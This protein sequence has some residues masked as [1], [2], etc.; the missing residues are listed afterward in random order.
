MSS[1]GLPSYPVNIAGVE[2]TAPFL[3]N[4]LVKDFF[5]Y[6]RNSFDCMSQAANVGCLVFKSKSID[7]V[8]FPKMNTV[9]S[10]QSYSCDFPQMF[11]WYS[12][13]QNSTEYKYIDAFCNRTK[14]TCDVYLKLSMS[15]LGDNHSADINP[16]FKKGVQHDKQAI[17]DCLDAAFGFLSQRYSD[18]LDALL[19][20]ISQE[21]YIE[22]RYHKLSIY[23]QK[24]KDSPE[25]SFSMAYIDTDNDIS[26]MPDSIQVL[27][28]QERDGDITARN[29]PIDTIYVKVSEDENK[30]IGKYIATEPC[31]DDT[32]LQYR[33]YEKAPY[34]E[35]TLPL[36]FQAMMDEKQKDTFYHADPFMDIRTVS[37]DDDFLKRVQLPF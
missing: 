26:S 23:Q 14:H 4:K 12:S 19:A 1:S 30:Y 9:F 33:R 21:K 6:V 24:M 25:S 22:H 7:T 16:F 34:Q 32:L 8:D 35:G 18:F 5:Q 13:V 20:E 27:F 10:Q 29:C 15:L 36:Q 2:T 37:D 28:L 17:V 31:G 3:V 11:S